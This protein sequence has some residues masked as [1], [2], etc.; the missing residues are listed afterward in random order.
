ME[1]IGKSVSIK[2]FSL[3][4]SL[5]IGLS[6]TLEQ[7][8]SARRFF[9]ALTQERIKVWIAGKKNLAAESIRALREESSL[10]D[11]T[12]SKQRESETALMRVALAL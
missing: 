12:S 5:V 10:E 8:A 11:F 2:M 4:R 6:L 1:S 3:I 7:K 9:L